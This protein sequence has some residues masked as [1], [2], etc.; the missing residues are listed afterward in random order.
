MKIIQF[1]RTDYECQNY[2]HM[3][4]FLLKSI[5]YLANQLYN[6]ESGFQQEINNGF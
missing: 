6:L 5:N 2:N 1:H 3:K 4:L